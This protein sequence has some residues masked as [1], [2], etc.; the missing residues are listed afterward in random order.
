[1]DVGFGGVVGGGLNDLSKCDG[2]FNE[3][4]HN[5]G[6]GGMGE[7]YVDVAGG[8]DVSPGDAAICESLDVAFIEG[9]DHNR[10]LVS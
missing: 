10:G 9:K 5:G 1:M 2:G 4:L 3:G 8:F 7:D 6:S